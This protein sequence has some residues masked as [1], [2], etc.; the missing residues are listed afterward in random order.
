MDGARHERYC[1]AVE[2]EVA[3]FVDLV[4]G[5][6]PAVPVPT[7][8]GWT[9]GALVKH[10]GTTHRWIEHLVRHLVAD[11]VWPR[12]VPLALPADAAEYPAWLAA[13]AVA[14][15]RTLREADPAA[16]MWSI[17]AERRVRFWPRRLLFEAV[18]HR[19]DAELALGGDPRI[20]PHTAA[21]GIDELLTLLPFFPEIAERVGALDRRG[22]TLHLHDTGGDGGWMITLGEGG[23][24]WRHKHGTA[25][26]AVAANASDLLLLVYGRLRPEDGRFELAGD[27]ALLTAWLGAT[28]L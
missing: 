10:H 28:A 25:T 2:A 11:R 16:P 22:A 4:R 13:G 26:A 23:P 15:L 3:R 1:A 17:G 18:I 14:C 20:D 9:I 8:P 19:A 7:C 12:D 6:D 27:R 5:A 24:G 21:D